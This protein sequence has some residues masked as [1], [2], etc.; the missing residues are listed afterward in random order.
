MNDWS[1]DYTLYCRPRQGDPPW[2]SLDRL[3]DF[4]GSPGRVVEQNRIQFKDKDADKHAILHRT[5]TPPKNQRRRLIANF[6]IT[7]RIAVVGTTIGHMD[8]SFGHTAASPFMIMR[9][10]NDERDIF[11]IDSDFATKLATITHHKLG[12]HRAYHVQH[13]EPVTF[14]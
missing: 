2:Q 14:S 11:Q 4:A 6:M 5:W 12:P 8:Y 10:S 3:E 7:D 9:N 1:F 13:Y